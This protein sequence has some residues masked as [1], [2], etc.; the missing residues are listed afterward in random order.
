MR[1]TLKI[2]G[3]ICLL[4]LAGVVYGDTGT[5]RILDYRVHLTPMSDGTV[6]IAYY[7]K[8]EVTGGHI[9]WITIGTANGDFQV[10]GYGHAAGDAGNDSQGGWT[11]VRLD[12]TEDFKPGQVFEASCVI[13]QKGLFYAD[14]ENYKMEF[15]PGW[16]DRA[17]IDTLR[18]IL[19]S[20]AKLETIKT[21]PDPNAIE[22]EELTWVE[23]K[24]SEGGRFTIIVT[25]PKSSLPAEI[26][27]SNLKDD[28]QGWVSVVFV[29]II[30]GFFIFTL[31]ARAASSGRKKYSG[32]NIFFGGL[33]GLFSGTGGSGSGGKSTG[34]GGGFGGRSSS[35]AC[36]CVSCACACACAGGGGAGCAKKTVHSC[37]VCA[38][39]QKS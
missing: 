4:L 39:R 20:F 14:G 27:Q 22:G 29:I 12:L 34:G 11:G 6:E 23:H 35:C 18:I 16:Y 1:H 5:Y 25:I 19:K 17:E 3:V 36:A 8:W 30:V 37:P 15:T 13:I 7:Q 24:I 33:P 2:L 26:P 28:S 9:P 38:P 31:I 21:E 10:K 32:G